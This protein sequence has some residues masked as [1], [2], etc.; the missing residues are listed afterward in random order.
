[1][2]VWSR[3]AADAD[4]PPP[5]PLEIR[6]YV[7]FVLDAGQANPPFGVQFRAVDLRRRFGIEVPDQMPG[8]IEWTRQIVGDARPTRPLRVDSFKRC[9]Q[10]R[11]RVGVSPIGTACP[12]D[13]DHIAALIEHRPAARPPADGAVGLDRVVPNLH[14]D[15]AAMQRECLAAWVA[16]QMNGLS[17]VGLRGF[18]K[19]DD[20]QVLYEL[21]SFNL[22]QGYVKLR[23]GADHGG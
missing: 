20:G 8:N 6:S 3:C 10:R 12:D 22:E 11:S 1:M 21:R 7:H 18:S 4:L 9:P 13:P 5:A 15:A 17:H 19:L 14:Y 23:V 16:N 2:V